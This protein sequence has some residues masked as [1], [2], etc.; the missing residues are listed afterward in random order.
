MLSTFIE[1]IKFI[2]QVSIKNE[3]VFFAQRKKRTYIGI[4]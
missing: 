4:K 3:G 2:K 1:D